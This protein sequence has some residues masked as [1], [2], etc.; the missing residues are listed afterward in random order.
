M[1]FG[2]GICAVAASMLLL[3]SSVAAEPAIRITGSDGVARHIPVSELDTK[4]GL[5]TQVVPLDFMYRAPKRLVG[6][7]LKDLLDAYE[8]PLAGDYLMVCED[9][10]EVPLSGQLLSDG[11]ASAF[12]ARGDA[13]APAGSVWSP[14]FLGQR[15]IELSPFYLAWSPAPSGTASAEAL[16]ERPWPYALVEIRLMTPADSRRPP[17]PKAE[18]AATLKQGFAVFERECVKCRRFHDA[19]GRLGPELTRNYKVYAFNTGQLTDMV[20]NIDRFYVDSKMPRYAGRLSNAE[21]RS[22]AGYLK[23]FV[24][25]PETLPP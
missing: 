5:N 16:L 25:T 21:L 14:L 7:P 22:V 9:G 2:A 11:S 10:Y 3:W 6:Y 13:D 12:L 4:L 20:A 19:G 24:D 1:R 15:P 17:E 18:A 8:L 23:H